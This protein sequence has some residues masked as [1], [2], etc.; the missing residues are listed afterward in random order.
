MLLLYRKDTD[1]KR[2]FQIKK[3]DPRFGQPFYKFYIGFNAWIESW[4]SA[5]Q[6]PYIRAPILC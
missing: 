6:H 1:V 3:A 4:L 2:E 5:L